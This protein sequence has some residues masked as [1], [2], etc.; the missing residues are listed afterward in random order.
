MNVRILLQKHH[1][2]CINVRIRRE[3]TR[4]MLRHLRRGIRIPLPKRLLR[5]LRQSDGRTCTLAQK[6]KFRIC[7][8]DA[9]PFPYVA[10]G[11]CAAENKTV[12]S[13]A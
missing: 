12:L 4:K 5:L 9:E 13:T 10:L 11:L 6:M 1:L 2:L 7:E 3:R 8:S